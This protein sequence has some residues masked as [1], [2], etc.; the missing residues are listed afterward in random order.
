MV[1][2]IA[3]FG[4]SFDPPHYGHTHL[5]VALREAY[6][7]DEVMVIPAQCNP[8]KPAV[9]SAEHRLA[10]CHLHFDDV[11]GCSVVD[12]EVR[13]PLASYTI[14][15]LH[16]LMEYCEGFRDAER[17]LLL[18]SDLIPSLPSWKEIEEV[19]AIARPLVAARGEIAPSSLAGLSPTLLQ[20]VCDGWTQTGRFDISSTEV[21]ARLCQGLYVEHLVRQ[22]VSQYI[23]QQ[24]LYINNTRVQ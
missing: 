24:H 4:G 15:T 2:K 14:D 18:G 9:A 7:L 12:C 17:F 20:A 16:W 22:G 21:R 1:G 23:Q 10:M 19:I 8:F 5:M 11:P 13:R 6:H 3:V